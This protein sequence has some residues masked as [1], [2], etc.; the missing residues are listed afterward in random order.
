MVK[1]GNGGGSD[2]DTDTRFVY[3][4]NLTKYF[5]CL[6]H[7]MFVW[8]FDNIRQFTVLITDFLK[9]LRQRQYIKMKGI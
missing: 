6:F 5:V 9:Q 7:C 3:V 4:Y 8:L 1:F 2:A